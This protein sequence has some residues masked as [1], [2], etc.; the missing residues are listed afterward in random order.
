MVGERAVEFE[1]HRYEVDGQAR[2]D[3]GNGVAAH[4]V[5]RVDDDLQRPDGR[6]VDQGQQVG[7]VVGERVALG[8]GAGDGDRLR[9]A[10]FG[11][12]LDQGADLQEP[13]VLAHGCGARPAELDAVVLRRVVRGGEHRAREAQAARGE[14]QLVGRAEADEGDVR[15]ARRG[16]P[17]EGSREAGR[18]GPHVVADH[19][20][21]R[22]RHLDE[23]RPEPLGQRLVPLI[24]HHSAHVVRL[25]DLRQISSHGPVL[26]R[27]LRTAQTTRRARRPSSGVRGAQHSQMAAAGDLHRIG[28]VRAAPPVGTAVLRPR[29]FPYGIG[30]RFEVVAA[31][32]GGCGGVGEPDD[33]PAAWCRQ[34]L[35]VLGA[36]VVAVGLGIGGERAEDRSR[37]G[38]DVR[39]CRDGRAAARSARTATYRAHDVG[40]YR[41]LERAA[42]TLPQVTP[43]CR[44]VNSRTSAF[45]TV[46]LTCAGTEKC[47]HCRQRFR[48]PIDTKSVIQQGINSQEQGQKRAL[49]G[50]IVQDWKGGELCP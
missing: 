3:G 13:G 47:Q 44:P 20:R 4:A 48:S 27:I 30:E 1:V 16:S 6:Q 9:G 5:A 32:A 17:C 38:I 11:P 22:A 25:H 26:L 41:T 37:V 34:P 15:A 42:T 35:T 2:E 46:V 10:R 36:E 8:D 18:R 12:L 7:R 45:R 23:R 21:V 49:I 39:Q 31:G 24:G 28:G 14:V 43:P 29:R 40:R 19:D 33:F 50:R